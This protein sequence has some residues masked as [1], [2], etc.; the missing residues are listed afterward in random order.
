MKRAQAVLARESG[1]GRGSPSSAAAPTMVRRGRCWLS[2]VPAHHPPS[3]LYIIYYIPLYSEKADLKGN[4]GFDPL[5]STRIQLLGTKRGW[6]CAAVKTLP[7]DPEPCLRRH[8]LAAPQLRLLQK[9][10]NSQY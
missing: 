8:Q 3:L 9:P 5:P 10:V 6:H 7:A 4:G 2:R 1:L